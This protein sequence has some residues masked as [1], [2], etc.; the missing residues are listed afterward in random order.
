LSSKGGAVVA[1][2]YGFT[3]TDPVGRPDLWRARI[4]KWILRDREAGSGRAALRPQEIT[5]TDAAW[6]KRD[7][8][9]SYRREAGLV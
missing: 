3:A 9:W 6:E 1:C 2:G 5:A 4:A 7:C 8:H